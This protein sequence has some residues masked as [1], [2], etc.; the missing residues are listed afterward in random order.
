MSACYKAVIAN[1]TQQGRCEEHYFKVYTLMAGIQVASFQESQCPA[2]K[3]FFLGDWTYAKPP[4]KYGHLED[5]RHVRPKGKQSNVFV[6]PRY[7]GLYAV[8]FSLLR[9]ISDTL[10]FCGGSLQSA[11]I[12]WGR[13]HVESAQHDQ[14][15][16]PDHTMLGHVKE[17][18]AVAWYVYNCISTRRIHEACNK[19]FHKQKY[20]AAC[21]F[22]NTSY[23]IYSHTLDFSRQN[24]NIESR[25]FENLANR[26]LHA[27]A[28]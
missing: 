16:G 18:I 5:V 3:R 24:A 15:F 7:R 14:I 26:G 11:I 28:K 6:V 8:E 17:H 1:N 27:A 13:K 9:E 2:C 21:E 25:S 22:S 10:G 20:Q 12:L 23:M 4:K 19:T